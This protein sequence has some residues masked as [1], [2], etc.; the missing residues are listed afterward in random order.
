MPTWDGEKTNFSG[1]WGGGIYT[2]S[3]HAKFPRAA[4]D[5]AIF[6]VGDKRNVVDV[7]N[8]D[9][10]TGAPTFPAYLKGNALWKKKIDADKY[11]NG[12]PYAAMAAQAGKV[13]TGVKPVRYDADGAWGAAY[14]PELAKSKDIQKALEAYATYTSNLAQQLGYEVTTK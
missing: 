12:S 4:L 3:P 13:W 5:F 2:I 1:E 14:A 6:M 7:K 9:G 8:P 11:Y 10:S